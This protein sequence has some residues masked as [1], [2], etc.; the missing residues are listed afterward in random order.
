MKARRWLIPL[1]LLTA[2]L[3]APSL[4]Y[5][6]L[7][8]DPI[9]FQRVVGKPWW[10]LFAPMPDNQFYRPGTLL[11]IRLFAHPDGTFPIVAMHAFQIG[12]HLIN[13]ALL[14]RLARLLR[15]DEATAS[16]AA[17]LFALFPP[18][19]QAVLWAAPQ[20]PWVIAVELLVLNLY[21][22]VARRGGWRWW[23][24]AA[25]FLFGMT[26]QENGVQVLPFLFLLEGWRRRSLRRGLR[27]RELWGFVL[28]AAGYLT[29]WL[30]M[31]KHQGEV[32]WGFERSVALYLL[33]APAWPLLGWASGVPDRLLHLLPWVEG[34]TLTL[35]ALWLLLL[36]RRGEW[37][38]WGVGWFVAQ[39]FTSWAGLHEAYVFLSPRLFYLAAPGLALLWAA[40]LRPRPE[41]GGGRAWPVRAALGGAALL[42]LVQ[43]GRLI[44]RQEVD[45]EAGLPPM[46]AAV[47]H[48]CA[49][50]GRGGTLFVNFPD[51]YR[52]RKPIYPL[53]YW[54]VTLAP[55]HVPLGRFADITC[56]RWPETLSLSFP[57]LD[58]QAREAMPWQVDMRGSPVDQATLY[59][60]A[61]MREGL[62]VV[63]YT[64][65]GE[66]RLVEA[67][68]IIPGVEG[69]PLARFGEGVEL[70]SVSMEEAGLRLRWRAVGPIS[71]EIVAFV[72]L[73][74]GEGKLVAQADGAPVA[75]LLPFAVWQPGDGVEEVRPLSTAEGKPIPAGRYRLEVGLYD[76]RT[77]ERLPAFDGEGHAL[78]NGIFSQSVERP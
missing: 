17:A 77:G 14:Y 37:L 66:M 10:Q 51:R 49:D 38:L 63:R 71:P 13:V 4:R 32:G 9:W 50:E 73:L 12:L 7:W 48:L 22:T 16:L 1:L 43:G 70:L 54:G 8:D 27:R 19:A 53:G 23:G 76:W 47:S 31:P 15:A 58:L 69:D 44:R 36:R 64:S 33:Q 42:I 67:G 57:A 46:E 30:L 68:H 34:G 56:G 25:L 29:L 55:I 3:Y 52:E 20:Q 39:L 24:L 45:Y 59:K 28:L 74:D 2:A 11:I 18:G 62:Y 72:H 21:P 75:T 41:E 6:F 40:A 60:E 65:R 35:L 78:P 5:G 26:I 61:R